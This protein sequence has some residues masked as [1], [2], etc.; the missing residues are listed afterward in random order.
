MLL[1]SACDGFPA[2]TAGMTFLMSVV[3]RG[4][5]GGIYRP[6]FKQK[7]SEARMKKIN[8]PHRHRSQSI[9][10]VTFLQGYKLCLLGVACEL[11]ILISHFDRYF[12]RCGAI[13]RIENAGQP[14]RGDLGQHL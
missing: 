10:M 1:K 6:S 3:P 8:P 2:T 4:R 13:V 11:P 12:N 9:P 14:P 5:L 7:F